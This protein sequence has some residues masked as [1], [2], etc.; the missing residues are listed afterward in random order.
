[1]KD[2]MRFN[3]TE[4]ADRRLAQVERALRARF[5]P[6]PACPESPLHRRLVFPLLLAA[7]LRATAADEVVELERIVVTAPPA[8]R[9]STGNTPK[10]VL[11]PI[12]VLLVPGS[13]ADINR[14]LQSLPGVQAADEGN[15]LFVRGGDSRETATWINGLRFPARAQINAP[16]GTYAG[17]ISPWQARTIDFAAGGFGADTGDV[18]SG[19]VKI[20][21]FG[22]PDRDEYSVNLAIGGAAFSVSSLWPEAKAGVTASI[23]YNDLQPFFGL[24]DFKR[25]FDEPPQGHTYSVGGA[26]DYGRDA[27]LKWFAYGQHEQLAFRLRELNADGVYRSDTDTGFQALSWTG[28]AGAWKH[29][30]NVG[31]GQT[32]ND[33]GFAG[34]RWRA[35]LDNA[36]FSTRSA[37]DAGRFLLRAG[38]EGRVEETSFRREGLAIASDERHFAVWSE[39]DA[40]LGRRVRLIGGLHA[41][42]S[43][44]ADDAAVDPR[45]AVVWQP[46]RS[47]TAS[48]AGGRYHQVA[49]GWNYADGLPVWP[50][51]RADQGIASLEWKSGAQLVRIEAY[52]KT[53]DAL[54][55]R[56]RDEFPRGGGRGTAQG[57]DV[58]WKTPLPADAKARL[59]WSLVDAERTDPSSGVRAPAPRAVKHS[60]TLILDRAFGDWSVSL[61]GRWNSG[62]PFTP[63]TGGTVD[64]FGRRVPVFGPA[65]SGRLP[66]FRRVDFTIVRLWEISPR[67]QAATYLAG[68]NLFGW[69]NTSGFSYSDDFSS[70]RPTP[71]IFQRSVYFGVNLA[72]R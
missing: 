27:Q 21:T 26:W 11:S 25:T 12:E 35:V 40:S 23:A 70:R 63:V 34:R 38:S 42:R 44:L 33:E 48:L 60:A 24:Y 28:A 5:S 4:Q 64:G 32:S 54:V 51:M 20:E 57:L 15:A 13:A 47:W 49:E 68:F 31:A 46:V 61:A 58:L 9:F 2:D 45:L 53:Y 17:S 65:N 18:L 22:A 43:R 41:W 16:L 50:A 1:M 71:G 39:A 29:E 19:A 7:T 37:Y 67:I 10:A 66:D 14:A 59:T 55:A 6:K 72:Y 3:F 52:A 56:D 8:G 69:E 36:Q 62:R 30:V